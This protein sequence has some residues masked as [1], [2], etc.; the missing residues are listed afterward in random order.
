MKI[1]FFSGYPNDALLQSLKK[2]STVISC[3]LE[4]N[5][6][7]QIK[8]FLDIEK[9]IEKSGKVNLIFL[10]EQQPFSIPLN[11]EKTDILKA[12]YLVD[13]HLHFDTWHKHFAQIFD[14]IFIAQKK[15][16]KKLKS[17]GYKNVFWLPLYCDP[18]IDKNLNLNRIYDIGFV[19]TINTFHNL[20][21]SIFLWLLEK[22]FKTK[23]GQ[24]VFRENRAQILNQAK[25]AVNLSISSDLNF[26]TFEAMSCGAML[27]TDEQ[28]NML[29]FFKNRKHLVIF[30]NFLELIKLA[31][32]YIKNEKERLKIAKIGQRETLNKHTSNNRAKEIVDILKLEIKAKRRLDYKNYYI[33]GRTHFFLYKKNEAIT[34]F[35]KFLSIKKGISI[36]RIE[37]LIFLLTAKYIPSKLFRIFMIFFRITYKILD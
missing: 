16:F 30:K 14:Y 9:I 2:Y 34:Y 28:D 6:Q 3:G 11:L 13:S 17:K 21:R 35:N 26:R 5:H 25:I 33:M 22:N 18:K 27:L 31:R 15:Y 7:I 23:I 29:E 12:V 4:K 24:N 37:A 10:L 32:F 19:G 20:K 8:D 36:Q 1:L